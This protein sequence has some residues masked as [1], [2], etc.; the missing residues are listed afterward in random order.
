MYI[1]WFYYISFLLYGTS[2]LFNAEFVV[3]I[4]DTL[5]LFGFWGGGAVVSGA[6]IQISDNQLPP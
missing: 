4:H 5:I 6:H 1:C 3:L 2:I